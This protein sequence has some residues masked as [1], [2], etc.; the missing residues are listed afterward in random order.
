MGPSPQDPTSLGRGKR[1]LFRIA[2]LVFGLVLAACAAEVALRAFPEALLG[3]DL[4]ATLYDPYNTTPFGMYFWEPNARM[5]VMW[6]SLELKAYSHGYFWTHRTD[7]RGFRN[8]ADR[9]ATGVLLLGDS[10]IYGHGVEDDQTVASFLQREYG[11]PAYN[12]ARQGD[13]LYQHYRLLRLYLDELS[14][15]T[16][17][18]FAFSNDLT[19]LAKTDSFGRAD[20]PPEIG[21][22]DYAAIRRSIER[23]GRNKPNVPRTS[24]FVLGRLAAVRKAPD[25]EKAGGGGKGRRQA[26]V[27]L[28]LRERGILLQDAKTLDLALARKIV[29]VPEVGEQ[30]EKGW[31]GLDAADLARAGQYYRRILRDL[32]ERCREKGTRLVLVNLALDQ[33]KY[34]R[35]QI[36]EAVANMEKRVGLAVAPE[37]AQ[38]VAGFIYDNRVKMTRQVGSVIAEVAR[39]D[40]ID[41]LDLSAAFMEGDNYLEDDGHLSELGHRRLAEH[42]HGFLSRK[43]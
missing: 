7:A 2:A 14:P 1:I 25:G 28:A 39:E 26:A 36:D 20:R 34:W 35:V 17:V 6:P 31:R 9:Q 10:M 24:R 22:Y 37:A 16:V 21:E 33:G 8:P 32:H 11:Y 15:R 41:Y 12:M 23:E 38:Y 29:S 42:L 18:L 19:D 5:N 3:A 27:L 30:L 43:K 13:C 40:G 4:T